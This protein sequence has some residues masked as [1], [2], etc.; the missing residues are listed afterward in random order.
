MPLV[1]DH[2]GSASHSSYTRQLK[3][4]N[5]DTLTTTHYLPVA[6]EDIFNNTMPSSLLEILEDKISRREKR[7]ICHS[8]AKQKRVREEQCSII[9]VRPN[10]HISTTHNHILPP[11]PS[12]K[13]SQ[14]CKYIHM[15]ST[16]LPIPLIPK[17]ASPKPINANKSK[18]Y[19][20]LDQ[21]APYALPKHPET[22]S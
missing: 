21:N 2:D 1:L 10:S 20:A 4:F 19:S 3:S 9:S 22:Q 13:I 8:F 12:H 6:I 11:C 5:S 7:S 14:S 16:Y 17:P 18:W 15:H